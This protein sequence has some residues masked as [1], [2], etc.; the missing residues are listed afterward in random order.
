MK[1]KAQRQSGSS[2]VELII[3]LVVIAVLLSLLLPALAKS[4][5]RTKRIG[6]TSNIK[7]I[8]LAFRI[9]SQD[10]ADQ[11]PQVSTSAS[12]SRAWANSPEVFRH[13]LVMSNELV[14]PKVLACNSD[15][16]RWKTADFAT[17]SNSNVTYFVGLDADA[18]KPQQL[19]TGDRNITG[20]TLSNG[21]LR[22]LTSTGEAGWTREIHVGV[23]NVG[24]AD[25]SAQQLIPERL[26]KQLQ[27]QE[28]PLVRLA[29]P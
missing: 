6:C 11:F 18:S 8:G 29:I 3:L 1:T 12:G 4:K 5:I 23:G 26:R 28:L 22:L 19:L 15:P 16:V 2:V 21:F 27:E 24:L 13:F 10:H 20:G 9:W 25:G 7:Q 14:T 17:L